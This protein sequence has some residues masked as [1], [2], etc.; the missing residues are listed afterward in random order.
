MRCGGGRKD[1]KVED[2][3][4]NPDKRGVRRRPEWRQ[5]KKKKKKG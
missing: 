1:L 5:A 2:R 3:K 4:A